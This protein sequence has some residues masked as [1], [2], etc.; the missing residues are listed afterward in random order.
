MNW[1]YVITRRADT[2][3]LRCDNGNDETQPCNEQ[4]ATYVA[5]ATC[6]H[7]T[8]TRNLCGNH[9]ARMA[10]EKHLPFPIQGSKP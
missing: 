10:A 4:G 8:V 1:G 7:R 5:A 3:R 2:G 9:A 6:G